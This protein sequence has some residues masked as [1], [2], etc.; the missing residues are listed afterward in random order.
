[1]LAFHPKQI[2]GG[3]V[4]PHYATPC[5]SNMYG[6][7]LCIPLYPPQPFRALRIQQPFLE[8]L[9]PSLQQMLVL[10][11]LSVALL[12]TAEALHAAVQLAPHGAVLQ[13]MLAQ[14]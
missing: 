8:A 3:E 10:L 11:A 4:P 14:V 9:S 2:E 7:L 12:P 13:L 6:V 1:M 5:G